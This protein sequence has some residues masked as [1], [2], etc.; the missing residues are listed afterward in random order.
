[1]GDAGQQ[2]GVERGIERSRRAAFSVDRQHT[3]MRE[4]IGEPHIAER[5]GGWKL[6]LLG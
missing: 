4:I 3:S 6:R 1:M 5:I 2:H